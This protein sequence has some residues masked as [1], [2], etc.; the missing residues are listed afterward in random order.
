LIDFSRLHTFGSVF[1][2]ISLLDLSF[3]CLRNFLFI[4]HTIILYTF[5][6]L[7]FLYLFKAN[8]HKTGPS[9]VN[10]PF[11]HSVLLWFGYAARK[12]RPQNDLLCVGLDVK[13]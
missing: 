13:P 2:L 10:R 1:K 11:C 9:C 3:K 5:L 4:Y 6:L 12:N 8:F 7:S